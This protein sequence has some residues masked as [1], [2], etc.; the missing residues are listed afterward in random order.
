MR[1]RYIQ[2]VIQIEEKK[3]KRKLTEVKK[4]EFVIDGGKSCEIKIGFD[5]ISS[6][7]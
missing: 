4:D 3:V 6:Q 5:A 1:G 2:N 7:P